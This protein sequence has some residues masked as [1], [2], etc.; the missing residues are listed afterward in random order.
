MYIIYMEI[1]IIYISGDYTAN[2]A[3]NVGFDAVFI[4]RILERNV[5][6]YSG[7]LKIKKYS[8]IFRSKM[9]L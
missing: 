8:L 1:Y 4:I 5:L 7:I 6:Q 9:S 3:N 2:I